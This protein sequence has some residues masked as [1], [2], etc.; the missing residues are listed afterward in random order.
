MKSYNSGTEIAQLGIIAS[1]RSGASIAFKSVRAMF[2]KMKDMDGNQFFKADLEAWKEK[3]SS[4]TETWSI[5]ADRIAQD[6]SIK[7]EPLDNGFQF[8]IFPTVIDTDPDGTELPDKFIVPANGS[9][10]LELNGSVFTKEK[11]GTYIVQLNEDWAGA[12]V[13]EPIKGRADAFV[14]LELDA[15]GQIPSSRY[16]SQEE[17][18]KIRGVPQ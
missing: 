5:T 14:V 12:K 17:A 9:F 13:S 18:D 6:L 7:I 16:V 10:T 3:G 4:S 8:K 11:A 15:S 2:L 1:N